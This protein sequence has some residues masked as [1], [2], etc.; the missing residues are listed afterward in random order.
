[1]MSKMVSGSILGAAFNAGMGVLKWG[2]FPLIVGSS[3]G[4]TS[5][6]GSL[7]WL[8]GPLMGQ[9]DSLAMA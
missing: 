6:A 3:K 1:M 9:C 4:V 5:G 7:G 2:E 8:H